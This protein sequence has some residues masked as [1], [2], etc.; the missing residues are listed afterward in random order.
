[1]ADSLTRARYRSEELIPQEAEL[2]AWIAI[3][4]YHP[5]TF[6]NRRKIVLQLIVLL[7][8]EG[9]DIRQGSYFSFEL[10]LEVWHRSCCSALCSHGT[11]V[12]N[13]P[14]SRTFGRGAVV[15]GSGIVIAVSSRELGRENDVH[16]CMHTRTLC[17]CS[18]LS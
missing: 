16:G 4:V 12:E 1:M 10:M 15:E 3:M 2:A 11:L 18:G 7:G 8:C 5:Y 17:C 6:I 14:M 13:I 9:H